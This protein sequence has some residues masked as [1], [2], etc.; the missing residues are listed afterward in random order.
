MKK[1]KAIKTIFS[2]K[3]R[4]KKPAKRKE[5]TATLRLLKNE[6][7]NGELK[8]KD[9]TIKL[10]RELAENKLATTKGVFERA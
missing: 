10:P 1:E 7:V 2:S 6:F 5:T 4:R 9:S 8:L 3:P